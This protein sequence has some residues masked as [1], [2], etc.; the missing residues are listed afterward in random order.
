MRNR[1]SAPT[2]WKSSH[3]WY[4]SSGTYTPFMGKSPSARGYSMMPAFQ[5]PG[6]VGKRSPGNL[7]EPDCTM[8]LGAGA[9]AEVRIGTRRS[10]AEV[11]IGTRRS[12]MSAFLAVV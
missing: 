5:A 2:N 8:L 1:W 11:R 7:L 9:P 6:D 12:P 3:R 10:D 4:L